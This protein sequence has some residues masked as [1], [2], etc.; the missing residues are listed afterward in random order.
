MITDNLFYTLKHLQKCSLNTQ[1][2]K[3]TIYIVDWRAEREVQY[4]SSA[5]PLILR[6]ILYKIWMVKVGMHGLYMM[7]ALKRQ[8][9][10]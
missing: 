7:I 4:L 6:E 8:E 2:L 10:W 1:L 3:N 9:I 5:R